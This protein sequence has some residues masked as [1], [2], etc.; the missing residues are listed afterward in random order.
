MSWAVAAAPPPRL[1]E[2]DL[3]GDSAPTRAMDES[4]ELGGLETMD[5]LRELGDE[6]TLGDIDGERRLGGSAGAARGGRGYGGA[7]G[8]ACAHPA[9]APACAGRNP[10]PGRPRR[11]PEDEESW[12]LR[13]LKRGWGRREC[14]RRRKRRPPPSRAHTRS[15]LSGLGRRRPASHLSLPA[16]PLER[17]RDFPDWAPRLDSPRPCSFR[18]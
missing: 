8:C 14:C 4:G 17:L 9:T 6:L 10:R 2:L 5:T 15:G 11:L 16:W 18:G 3:T 7:G 1:P 13:G 12:V